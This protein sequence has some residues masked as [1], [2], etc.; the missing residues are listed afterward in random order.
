M[1][2]L[3]AI[4][5][6]RSVRRYKPDPV[7]EEIL[8][9]ILSAARMAPSAD[10]AQPWKFV[11]VT[12]EEIKRKLVQACNSQKFIA[13]APIVIVGCGFPDDAYATAGGYMNSFVMDV[14]IAMDHLILAATSLGLGSCWIA[15]FKEEKVREIIGIPSDARVVA[16]TPLGYPNEV[17]NKTS[18]K[19]LAELISYDKFE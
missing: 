9:E 11:V 15:A 19:S 3:E 17:P 18:R 1:D 7:P 12:D 16:L 10:N 5:T 13:E 4:K 2:V 6:R 14:M 8:K